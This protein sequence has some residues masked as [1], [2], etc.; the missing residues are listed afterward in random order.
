MCQSCADLDSTCP[1]GVQEHCT[2]ATR[3]RRGQGARDLRLRAQGYVRRP[4]RA[5]LL[6]PELFR[7]DES[8][9]FGGLGCNAGGAAW[10][11]RHCGF[12]TAGGVS[13]PNCPISESSACLPTAHYN[14]TDLYSEGERARTAL[15]CR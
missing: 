10:N 7:R 12:T 13:Y 15:I 11:C 14:R 2:R 8:V 4:G 1:H 6:R 9:Y 3:L 5:V